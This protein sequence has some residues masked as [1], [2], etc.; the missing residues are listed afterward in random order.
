AADPGPLITAPELAELVGT[1]GAPLVLDIRG[2]AYEQGHIEGATSAPY[3][4][5]RGPET[6][7]GALLPEDRLQ[8]L[9]RKLGITQ[10]RPVVVVHQGSNATDFGAAARVYWTLKSSGL[11]DLAILDG[12]AAAWAAAGLPL[13]T[14]T[15]TPEVSDI[16]ISFSDRWLATAED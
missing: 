5:F 11:E 7:P 8:S 1:A 10:E 6:N 15:N 3:A 13:E 12:G 16:T 2:P 14:Q 9:L 4:L